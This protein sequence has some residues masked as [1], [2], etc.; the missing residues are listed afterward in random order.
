MS[1][2]PAVC[3][4]IREAGSIAGVDRVIVVA[5]NEFTKDPITGEQYTGLCLN[6]ADLCVA[7]LCARR[8]KNR[9]FVAALFGAG[10]VDRKVVRLRLGNMAPEHRGLAPTVLAEHFRD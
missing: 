7:K 2:S 5:S 6:R 8:E 1:E 9:S 4:A 3:L 10:L